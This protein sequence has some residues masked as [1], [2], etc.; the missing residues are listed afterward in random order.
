MRIKKFFYKLL[1]GNEKD[2]LPVRHSVYSTLFHNLH[3][4]W[5]NH[6]QNDVGFEK[7]LRLFL[8]GVQLIFPGLHIRQYFSKKG[9]NVRNVAN[10]FYVLFKTLLPLV[11]LI[12][13]AYQSKIAIGI[14]C[15][16]LFE[17]ICY[18][19]SLIFVSDMFVKPRS[20]RRNILMLFFNYTEIALDFA[21]IYGGLHL[22]SD[23]ATNVADYIYFSVITSTT[24][25]FGDVHPASSAGKIVVCFHAMLIV[26]FI[27]LFLN[28]FSSKV[29]VMHNDDTM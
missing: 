17:T 21:V 3:R 4:I 24:I 27:V 15:Y 18:V 29:E 23:N 19:S 8:V 5:N 1:L 13:G 26:S 25:G 11:F 12:T 14:S 16:L 22:L 2:N 6:K 9:M 10:E 20:Y 7:I 28:F